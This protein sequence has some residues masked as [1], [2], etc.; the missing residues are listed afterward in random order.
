MKKLNKILQLV[1]LLAMLPIDVSN[2]RK[3]KAYR[4]IKQQ[5]ISANLL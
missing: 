5:M 4:K 3:K 2:G 1:K